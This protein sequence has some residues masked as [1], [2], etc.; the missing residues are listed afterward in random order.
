MNL[1]TML[2]I[3]RAHIKRLEVHDPFE[4][5]WAAGRHLYSHSVQV[6]FVL[7]IHVDSE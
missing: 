5:C 2:M 1:V 7:C 3:T 4:L 6:D